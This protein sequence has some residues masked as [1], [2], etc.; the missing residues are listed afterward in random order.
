MV[1]IQ[2]IFENL[3]KLDFKNLIKVTH[4]KLLAKMTCHDKKLAT[5][6]LNSRKK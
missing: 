2:Y 6:H 5:F 1:K 4:Q 3:R